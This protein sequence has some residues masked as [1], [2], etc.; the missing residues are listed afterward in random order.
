MDRQRD[1]ASAALHL[2]REWLGR[3]HRAAEWCATRAERR[4]RTDSDRPHSRQEVTNAARMNAHGTLLGT[5][6]KSS[7]AA[8]AQKLA[9]VRIASCIEIDVRTPPSADPSG[10]PTKFAA[11]E[12]AN[13][14]PSHAA[15]VRRWRTVKS[16]MS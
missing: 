4:T 15:S 8:S 6:A 3:R 5:R 2:V 10:N 13:A 16:A 12:T 9:D 7:T 1:A 11:I 14:R